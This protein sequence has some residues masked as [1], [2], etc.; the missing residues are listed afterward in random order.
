MIRI[1]N[2]IESTDRKFIYR[3]LFNITQLN[4]LSYDII[5]G[6]LFFDIY[7]FIEGINNAILLDGKYSN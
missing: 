5:F 3:N 4:I 6:D 7:N 1:Y 2:L